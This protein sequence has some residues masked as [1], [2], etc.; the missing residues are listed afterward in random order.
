MSPA[1]SKIVPAM[2]SDLRACTAALALCV[3]AVPALSHEFW[4]DAQAYQIAPGAPIVANLRVGEMLEGAAYPYLERNF[5]RFDMVQGDATVPV[6]GRAGD[7]PAL[8]MPAPGNGLAVVVHTTRAYSLT[9]TD[10]QKFINFCKHKAFEWALE[11]H[12]ARGLP[13][14]GF[15][16]QY[17]RHAKSLIAVGDGQGSDRAVGLETE[18][19]AL[20]NPYTDDLSNGLPVRVLYKNAPRA[21]AQVELYA[22]APDSTV[23]VTLFTTD[24]QGEATLTVTPGYRYLADA[25]VLRAMSPQ[26]PSDPVWESLWASLTFAVP[27]N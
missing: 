10:W 24:D 7:N 8:N 2:W 1:W 12:E 17:I 5:Q 21:N 23:T 14:E 20:A 25:V 4:I 13:R 6:T 11:Q 27:A 15:K 18:I 26:A 19:I 16:E 3:A 9:Y 22:Q